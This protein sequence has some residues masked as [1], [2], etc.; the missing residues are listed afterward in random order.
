[1]TALEWRQRAAE[2]KRSGFP[3]SEGA[4]SKATAAYINRHLGKSRGH[5]SSKQ[6]R[7]GHGNKRAPNVS[8]AM[9]PTILNFKGKKNTARPEYTKNFRE[10]AILQFAGM[11]VVK[12]QDGDGRR[13]TRVC[14]RKRCRIAPNHYGIGA[15]HL[16]AKSCGKCVVVVKTCHARGP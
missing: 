14:K 12:H 15:V 16:G 5:Q 8:H 6:G 10:G 9:Q 3:G 7:W 4:D 13:K 1:M 11:Q 2:T